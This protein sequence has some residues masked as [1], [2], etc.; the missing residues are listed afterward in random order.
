MNDPTPSTRPR[1]RVFVFGAIA[2]VLAAVVV[3]GL[4]SLRTEPAS[5][6]SA[7]APAATV[8]M[9]DAL[10]FSPAT[11]RIEAGQS[12]RWTNPS[13]VVHTATGESFDSGD[14]APGQSYSHTFKAPGRYR[15]V[16]VPHE[17]AGMV[18]TV[19]VGGE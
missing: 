15:Y 8:R 11:V 3:L 19:I 12:V 18:G 10:T 14:V 4:R 1:R 6:P 5:A 16:C 2:L 7:E 13:K 9:T 17:G